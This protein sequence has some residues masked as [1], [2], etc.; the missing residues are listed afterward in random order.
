MNTCLKL[1]SVRESYTVEMQVT[2]YTAIYF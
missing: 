1:L 2:H